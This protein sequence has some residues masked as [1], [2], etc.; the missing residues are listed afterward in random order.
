L[1][2]DALKKEVLVAF[3]YSYLHEDW[4]YPLADALAGVT[5]EDAAWRPG[6]DVKGIWDIVLHMAVWTENIVLRKRS[7][8]PV[9]PEEGAWPPLPPVPDE[10]AWEAAQSRLWDALAA[11]RAQ[12]EGDPP[13][14]LRNGPYGL[15]DLLCR[16]I[17]NA[18]HIGQITKMRELRDA[19]RE[20]M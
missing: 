12:I 3:D 9:R 1:D 7:G 16:F 4:V 2:G 19:Q 14:A 5:A 15:P 8:D 6:T 11:L 13:A 17:H 20:V 10:A 18:Y